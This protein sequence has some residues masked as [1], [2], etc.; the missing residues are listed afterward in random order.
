M[1]ER[2]L[3]APE[4]PLPVDDPLDAEELVDPTFRNDHKLLSI[5]S[6]P[7]EQLTCFSLWDMARSFRVRIVGVEKINPNT[8]SFQKVSHLHTTF[9]Q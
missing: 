5:D 6:K 4:K 3:I 1:V 9:E 2:K 8:S 7:W